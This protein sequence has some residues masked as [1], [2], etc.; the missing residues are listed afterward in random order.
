MKKIYFLLLTAMMFVGSSFAQ[1][2]LIDPT[3]DGG[4]E[5]GATPA[6]SG[7]TAVNGAPDSWIV[8]TGAAVSAG[9]N[10]AYIANGT[11]WTYSQISTIQHLYKDIAIP[12]GNTKLALSFK[13]K[14]GGEGSGT[15]DWDNMKVFLAP[16]TVT[17]TLATA[18]P[19]ANQISGAGA[20][21]AMYKLNSAAY[22][23]ET[24]NVSV[25][26]GTTYRD[27]KSTRLNSSHRNTSRMPSSA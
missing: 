8:G 7:W 22:N 13:W 11:T 5:I 26:P 1:T 21:S 15:S 17:P 14:V 18:I 4:F 3:T 12:A 9:T 24:I 16:T 27:R 20:V 6:A 10:A 2:T 19:V 23:S 25:I